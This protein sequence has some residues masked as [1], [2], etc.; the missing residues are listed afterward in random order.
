MQSKKL[1]MI[2]IGV[3]LGCQPH[4]QEEQPGKPLTRQELMDVNKTLVRKDNQ[5]ILGY[6]TRNG[7]KMEQ[8][9]TGLWYAIESDQKGK[10]ARPG[11]VI[12]LEYTLELLDGTVCY[13]SEQDGVKEF[14]IGQGGVES[15]LEE[16]VLM[17]RE[18]DKALL[19][20]PP[21]LAHGLTGDGKRIPARAI[22]MYTLK[23]KS[24]HF[25]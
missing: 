5:R 18:G 23:V 16:A 21:H 1:Y 13:N 19:I 20:M 7:L 12:R 24:I 15:G 10:H 3:L 17:L 4:V 11:D 9:E 2:G 6:L 22:I 25:K 14:E 8:T